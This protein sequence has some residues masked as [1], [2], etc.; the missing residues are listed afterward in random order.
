[1]TFSQKLFFSLVMSYPESSGMVNGKF[2][3][4]MHCSMTIVALSILAQN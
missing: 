1:M 2:Y 4:K 3:P